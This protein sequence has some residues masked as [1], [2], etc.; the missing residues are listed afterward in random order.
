VRILGWDKCSCFVSDRGTSRRSGRGLATGTVQKMTC[1]AGYFGLYCVQLV[2]ACDWWRAK[3]RCCYAVIR[4]CVV[5]CWASVGPAV[6]DVE[7]WLR[8][9]LR[10][11]NG[12]RAAT[13]GSCRHCRRLWHAA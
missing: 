7:V 10:R 4:L 6:H 9:L 1:G 12:S 11:V 2:L 5:D 8:S 3:L 13:R